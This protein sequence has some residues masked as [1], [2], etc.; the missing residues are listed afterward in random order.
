M[1]FFFMRKNLEIIIINSVT[2]PQLLLLGHALTLAEK[3][4][5][6]FAKVNRIITRTVFIYPHFN[7]IVVINGFVSLLKKI[8]TGC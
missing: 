3:P 4:T 1:L 7:I 6:N 5:S 2:C 8:T